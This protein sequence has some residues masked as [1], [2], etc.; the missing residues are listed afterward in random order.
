[1]KKTR[2]FDF[3]VFAVI[4]AL[5][6]FPFIIIFC[7]NMFYYEKKVFFGILL[8]V[9]AG[10]FLYI[11]YLF[12]WKA[13]YLDQEGAHYKSLF[14]PRDRLDLISEY[15]I[16]FKEPVYFLRDTSVDYKGLD[17]KE[18]ALKQIRVQA[19]MANT[20]KLTEYS[21]NVMKPAAKPKRGRRG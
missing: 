4:A 11:I 20:R 8:P 6:V 14:I 19:T 18:L 13:P 10:G 5:I 3:S 9:A 17:D 15:D 1:M 21:G 16:R 7:F 12:V 2:L